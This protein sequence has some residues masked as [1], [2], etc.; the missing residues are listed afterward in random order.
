M[1]NYEAAFDALLKQVTQPEKSTPVKVSKK[2]QAI[3]AAAKKLFSEKGFSATTTASI[4][5]EAHTTEKTLFKHFP[6]KNDLVLNVC[7]GAIAENFQGIYF[8]RYLQELDLR[9]AL[10]QFF[11]G[12]TAAWLK[13]SDSLKLFLQVIL[14]EKDLRE[15]VVTNLSKEWD[16]QITNPMKEVGNRLGNKNFDANIFNIFLFSVLIGYDVL[17]MVLL[18]DWQTD[19]KQNIEKI[20]DVLLFGFSGER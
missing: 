8:S 3:L 11:T 17:R 18:P 4:A 15:A 20:V 9:E 12:K 2:K 14:T 6:S 7:L 19:D 13:D 1:N 5:A 10:I 16:N